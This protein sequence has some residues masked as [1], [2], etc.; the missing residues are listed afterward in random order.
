M[1]EFKI[2][3]SIELDDE[4]AKAQLKS[5]QTSAKENNIKLNVEMNTSSLNN[6]KQL[7]SVLT[8]INAL[9]AKT[10]NGLFG[11]KSA[12]S[13]NSG[14]NNLISD[15]QKLINKKN[16]IEK[17]MSKTTNTQSYTELNGQLTRTM[18]QI[19]NLGSA[20]DNLKEKT[21]VNDNAF[22]SMQ[23]S[24]SST[25]QKAQADIQKTQSQIE[26]FKQT[27]F[28]DDTQLRELNKY[29]AELNRLSKTELKALD[30]KGMSNLLSGIS[31]VKT[32][33]GGFKIADNGINNLLSQYKTLMNE[34]TRLEKEFSKTTNIQ[35]YA[36]L[37]Q[38]LSRVKEKINSVGNALKTV[39]RKINI[40]NAASE[41]MK[42]SLAST[43]QKAQADMQRMQNQISKFKQ[44]ANLDNAQ[45]ATLDLFLNKLSTLSNIKLENLTFRGMSKLLTD[46]KSI[47]TEFA[48]FKIPEIN[49]K[50]ESQFN[51]MQKSVDGF[52]NKLKQ[53]SGNQYADKNVL[54]GLLSQAEKLK[55]LDLKNLTGDDLKKAIADLENLELRLKEV[56]SAAN[57][58][59]T[60]S[61][62]QFNFDKAISDLKRLKQSALE[63]GQSTSGIEKLEKELM[64]LANLPLDQKVSKLEQIQRAINNM[65]KST[66]ALSSSGKGVNKFFNDFTRSFSYF[67]LGNMAA[68]QLQNAIRGVVSTYKELDATM[69]DLKKVA[70]PVDI[71]SVQKLDEIRNKANQTAKEVGMTTSQVQESIAAS[72]QAGIGGMQESIAAARQSMILANVGDMSVE[73]SSSAVNTII[74]GFRIEPLKEM[75]V[76]VGNTTKKTT[77]LTAAMDMLNCLAC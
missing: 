29:S 5:L 54:G 37:E 56:Q 22:D 77:E 2:K 20:L 49:S 8:K 43:F 24:L 44:S 59:K 64:Q 10:Q 35:S 76:Q 60:K 28:L 1:S 68:M 51:S 47:Q 39:P 73:D 32:D 26:K 48:N 3:T 12:K 31:R 36:Q 65:N 15:Y 70:D 25:F 34:K 67:T 74:N 17:Q 7:E 63:L 46:I 50:V 71:N 61:E 16:A 45:I 53:L 69:T 14:V 6:L 4:K 38:Q 13:S 30:F 23:R 52:I 58:S 41:T 62:F 33:L 55:S 75:E 11:G 66:T 21:N 72:L 27:K 57:V 18:N 42:S 40:D 19:T 9:S